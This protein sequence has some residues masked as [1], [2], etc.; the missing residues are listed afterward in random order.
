MRGFTL[1]EL[2]IVITLI[3]ILS[4]AVLSTI[5]PIEQTNKAKDSSYQNDA[6]EVLNAYERYFAN[7]QKYPWM[8]FTDSDSMDDGLV[9]DDNDYGF[10]ICNYDVGNTATYINAGECADGAD[11]GV[12]ISSDELKASF[13]NKFQFRTTS[14]RI[15]NSFVAVKEQSSS[16]IIS[17]CF[18]PKSKT[19]RTASTMKCINTSVAGDPVVNAIGVGGCVGE[20]AS[21]ATFVAAN[22]D[23]DVLDVNTDNR[24]IFRCVPE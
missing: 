21:G 8:N 4:V 19:A 10:G 12:L 9:L 7:V 11:A 20:P 5:N 15:S 17:I 2:L 18:I 24:A 1:V 14:D 23:P 16:G 22:W 13:A 6:A 3:A